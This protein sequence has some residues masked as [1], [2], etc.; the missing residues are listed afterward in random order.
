MALRFGISSG[1]SS[2]FSLP[3]EDSWT[4]KSHLFSVL[5]KKSGR[6]ECV[7]HSDLETE[8]G[9]HPRLAS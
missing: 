9:Q 3:K 5:L 4:I 6:L 2:K 7:S 1:N 8:G